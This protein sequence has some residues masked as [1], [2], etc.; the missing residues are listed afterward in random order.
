MGGR[1]NKRSTAEQVSAGVDLTGRNAIVTGANTGIGWETARV[2]ALR[3]AHVTLACRNQSKASEALARLLSSSGGQLKA[4]QFA[5]LALDLGS[6]ASVRRFAEQFNQQAKALHLLINN[7]GV[8]WPTRQTT[9]DGFE[10][11][12]GVNHLGHF[13][14]SN[15]LLPSLQQAEQARVVVVSSSAMLFGQM[16]DAFEDLQWQHRPYKG[17]SCYGDSKL[18][19]AMFSREFNKRHAAQGIVSNALH[20]GII[21]TELGR[22]QTWFFKLV[23][24]LILPFSKNVAQGAATTVLVATA[25]DYADKGGLYFG[26]CQEWKPSKPIVQDDAACA[27]LWDVSAGLTG[28]SE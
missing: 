21:T 6:L 17:M 24:S 28:F 22:E 10:A 9:S 8:M 27:K 12:M 5:L 14:L 23:G 13:L 18:A 15:L 3:G 4:E 19:N 2:L 25:Q 1:F 26:D 16:T 11:Q 7:A 20:P